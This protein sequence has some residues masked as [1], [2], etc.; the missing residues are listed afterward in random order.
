M[1]AWRSPSLA[2]EVVRN[3]NDWYINEF[4]NG[5]PAVSHGP[6]EGPISLAQA[7]TY[8]AMTMKM[9][10]RD[11]SQGKPLS[12]AAQSHSVAAA[13]YAQAARWPTR[14]TKAPRKAR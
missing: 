8:V 4:I 7:L 9:E 14:P 6:L 11:V 12:E 13:V 10:D 3:R 1:M 5:A 2:V